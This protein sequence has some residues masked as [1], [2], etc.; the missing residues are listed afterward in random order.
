MIV[1]EG[2]C[3]DHLCDW[4]GNSKILCCGFV[5]QFQSSHSGVIALQAWNIALQAWNIGT[6][7]PGLS[8]RSEF[9]TD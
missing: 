6:L 8:L 3:L 7:G 4:H 2:I 5:V 1:D 9:V